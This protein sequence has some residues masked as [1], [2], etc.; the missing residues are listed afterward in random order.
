MLGVQPRSRLPFLADASQLQP[1]RSG[2]TTPII[3]VGLKGA[4]R[5]V[6]RQ[7][8]LAPEPL[9][10][11]MIIEE[12]LDL[13]DQLPASRPSARSASMRSS[14]ASSRNSTSRAA[15][16]RNAPSSPRPANG[17]PRQRSSASPRRSPACRAEPRDSASCPS[18]ASRSKRRAST[19]SGATASAYPAVSALISAPA[20]TA[21]LN[22][23]MY[24]RNVVALPF[25]GR[26]LQPLGQ[27][28]G[29]DRATRF[30]EQQREQRALARAAQRHCLITTNSLDRPEQPKLD[31][32]VIGPP[33]TPINTPVACRQQ[34]RG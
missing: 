7:H 30:D 27:A 5:A 29:G 18:R 4:P 16:S 10:V 1:Q 11:R 9:T 21:A 6:E 14:S 20:P 2:F 12:P 28:V 25:V 19:R 33:H 23:E 3:T 15:S 26:P 17:S 24:A 31:Q 22:L 32:A 13:V 34:G 8:Q